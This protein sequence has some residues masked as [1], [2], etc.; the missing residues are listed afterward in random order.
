M[1]AV[2][3]TAPWPVFVAAG[4]VIGLL[5]GLFGVGG[6]SIATPLLAVLGVPGL[7]AVASPLPATIPAALGAAVP[8]LQNGEARPRAGRLDPARQRAGGYRWCIPFPGNWWLCTACRLRHG[9]HDCR[10]PHPQAH[11]RDIAGCRHDPPQEPPDSRRCLS[12]PR[13]LL[14]APRQRWRVS[15][16]PDV[17]A[18]FWSRHA[19]GCRNESSRHLRPQ[20]ADPRCSRCPRAHQ[21][22]CCRCIRARCCPNE[23]P[24]RATRPT[25][26]QQW[27]ETSVW[28]VPRR[29]W[30][31]LCSLPHSRCLAALCGTRNGSGGDERPYGG[32][33]LSPYSRGVVTST[34]IETS[35]VEL[36]V[37]L[38][39]L[40]DPVRVR[41]LGVLARGGCCVCN[42][43][44][45]VPIASNLL[46][47]HLRVL[48]EAGLVTATRR[49][50]W[51]DY[52]LDADGF[53]TLWADMAAAGL[54]LPGERV[55]DVWLGDTCETAESRR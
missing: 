17:P 13:A 14:W 47:Y 32:A 24:E 49:G 37:R 1:V 46:S 55:T 41:V 11:C 18:Y 53:A 30:H 27:P 45:Q 19:S 51:V 4:A 2:L 8:Y 15:A 3:F 31:R 6:S 52:C 54:P 5:V 12:C 33:C 9:P 21:L 36:T 48:R 29:L 20:P 43:Q 10:N 7:L 44:D 38:A 34:V 39:A 26:H 28:L 50:R 16:R 42:L 23:R 22:D 25:G 35:P 40:A